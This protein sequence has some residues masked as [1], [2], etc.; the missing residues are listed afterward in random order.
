MRSYI[1]RTTQTLA[2][3]MVVLS[4]A[5]LALAMWTETLSVK[6]TIQTGYLDVSYDNIVVLELQ[7]A[8]GKDVG[9]CTYS[10]EDGD[11]T[12]VLEIT[13]RNGYPGYACII[14]F[15][16][17]NTGSIPV[18]GP[19]Y[20]LS[21]IPEGIEVTF[22]PPRIAQLHPGDRA[23]YSIAVKVLQEADESAEYSVTIEITYV[24][25]NEVVVP[26][27]ISGYVWHD[28]DQDGIWDY[29]LE[30]PLANVLV[31]LIKEGVVVDQTYTDNC[32]YYEFTVLPGTYV[33]VPVL[34]EGYVFTTPENITIYAATGGIFQ[35][36]NFG[37]YIPPPPQPGLSVGAEFR[38][39]STNFKECPAKLGPILEKITVK[40]K[41]GK[42]NAVSPGAFYYIV[43]I[44]G[45]G[46]TSINLT[47][48]YEFHFNIEDGEDGPVRA[49]LLNTTTGC[50][51]EIRKNLTYVVNNA[52]DV[53]IANIT[54]TRPLGQD[55]AVIIL[56]KFKPA[57][58]DGQ[59]WNTLDKTFD[60]AYI[61]E[62][63]IGSINGTS[64]IKIESK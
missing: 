22:T 44:T 37:M 32:G 58:I 15:D 54:F 16:V 29:D 2:V 34:L 7:E 8:E 12:D 57:G 39:T 30:S 21:T 41:Q 18:V 19:F 61:V 31:L 36:N 14:H 53:A 17:V 27:T 60:V 35:N 63:N 20:N 6:T 48:R 13:I 49:Y 59:P 28:L 43:N 1:G 52:D 45:A 47:L 5:A 55:S 64:F 38:E 23:S 24:Q 4:I 33:I 25:W 51:T 46:I 62:T 42:V 3:S 26:A 50:A 56:V 40:L 11:G 10:L 9:E